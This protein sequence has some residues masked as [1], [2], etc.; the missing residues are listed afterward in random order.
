MAR[1]SPGRSR[2]PG[3]GGQRMVVCVVGMEEGCEWSLYAR[4]ELS[5]S[6]HVAPYTEGAADKKARGAGYGRRDPFPSLNPINVRVLPG[7]PVTPLSSPLL[8]PLEFLSLC[9]ILS[10]PLYPSPLS[11]SLHPRLCP[12]PVALCLSFQATTVPGQR[13]CISGPS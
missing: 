13:L 11:V 2:S 12:A 1:P 7:A 10:T 8:Y 3:L 6:M 9:M 5:T 4:A